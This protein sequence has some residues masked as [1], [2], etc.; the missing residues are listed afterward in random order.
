MKRLKGDIGRIRRHHRF[1][2]F[3]TTETLLGFI[4]PI[5]L[6]KKLNFE[7]AQQLAPLSHVLLP[8]PCASMP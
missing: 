4:R 3:M 7:D 6:V 8:G 1:Y 2:H 5:L